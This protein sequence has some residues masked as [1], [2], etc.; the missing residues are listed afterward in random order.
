MNMLDRV[1]GYF[2]PESGLRRT[3]ARISLNQVR[4]YDGAKGG[5]RAGDWR[6]TNASANVETKAALPRLRARSRDLVRNTWWGQRIEQVTVSHTVGT[7]IIPKPSTGDKALD[8]RVKRA[9]KKWAKQCDREGQLNF[10]GLQA[11]AVRCIMESGEVLGRMVPLSAA[12]ATRGVVPLELQ[13]LEPDHLDQSRD[14]IMMV[15]RKPLSA[16]NAE[17]VVVD[18][19]IE[20]TLAGKR[21]A[22]WIYP[23]HP[24]ARGLVMPS[25]SV[26][27][28]AA[29][30]L[31]A[32]RK[33]RI[34]QGRG[35]PWLAPVMLTG[36]DF[37]D[38]QEAIVVKARIESC[39]AAFI[40]TN[41]TAR[42]LAQAQQESNG[43]SA[44]RRIESFAPGMV[45]YLEP[46]EE[47]QTV[48]PSGS[49]QFEGVL[50]STLQAIAAGAG[51]TYDQLTG[52]LSRAN[53][54]SLK[55]GKIE[56][57]RVVEQFQHLT[58]VPMF[59]EPLWERWC[60]LAVLNGILP[61]REEGYPVEWI[62]PA[63]EPI[64]PMKE[65]QADILAVRS[66]RMTWPQFV[67]A[68]GFD[69]DTQLDEIESWFGELDKRKIILDTDPRVALASTKGGAGAESQTEVNTNVAKDGGGK[70]AKK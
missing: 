22:Y 27:V 25:A 41:S 58:L 56:F 16:I 14:R 61:E 33:D 55:A 15:E 5:R 32:Y 23:V 13:L 64:D 44:S 63:W 70:P 4:S 48:A 17:G 62:M 29:D 38:L 45:A 68:W 36:R 65:L 7:G 18:Q 31:H 2:S 11:L 46:G 43:G 69:P 19:G 59:L 57:R 12:E 34:G 66:G 39:L 51:I 42:T 37:A 24:G 6:A 50:K 35:V 54:S 52:D 60:E 40:K 49:M 53:F 67:L 20:Y 26:R 30:M 8:K 21:K 47:L 28:P 1:V 3:A 9:W 10:E